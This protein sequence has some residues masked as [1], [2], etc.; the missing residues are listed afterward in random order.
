MG[1]SG[2][3]VCL[4]VSTKKEIQKEILGNRIAQ[5]LQ[6]LFICFLSSGLSS[7]FPAMRCRG[8]PPV[9]MHDM[10]LCW[11]QALKMSLEIHFLKDVL[12]LLEN[13]SVH[14]YILLRVCII[15]CQSE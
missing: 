10:Y 9:E 11:L 6:L 12:P 5:A 13:E 2:V 1:T 4:C 8:S 7:Q 14:D 3:S 15:L